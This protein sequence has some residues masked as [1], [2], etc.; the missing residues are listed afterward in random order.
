MSDQREQIQELFIIASTAGAARVAGEERLVRLQGRHSDLT[1][2]L[3]VAEKT[4]RN[5]EASH[6]DVKAKVD[7]HEATPEE[8]AAV[9]AAIEGAKNQVAETKERLASLGGM[10]EEAERELP[11]LNV[12]AQRRSRE[13]WKAVEETLEPGARQAAKVLRKHFSAKVA[14]TNSTLIPTRFDDFAQP[15]EPDERAALLLELEQEY[16]G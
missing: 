1:K 9:S 4:I 15:P 3:P 8:V 7:V 5:L 12:D 16:R 11:H 2:S 13:A 6:R 14:A 10:I